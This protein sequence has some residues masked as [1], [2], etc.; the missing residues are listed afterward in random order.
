MTKIAL[1]PGQGSQKVGMGAELFARFPHL[2]EQASNILGYDVRRLCLED[3]E[4]QLNLTQFTQPALFV[5]DTLSYNAYREEHGSVS[6]FAGHSLGEF[7]ALHAAGAFDFATGLRIVQKRGDLMAKASGGGMAAIIGLAPEEIRNVLDDNALTS[8][9]IANFNAPSQT[10]I[11]GPKDDVLA[12]EPAFKAAK[13]R[14]FPLPVSAAFHSR[15]MATAQ[16]A[17]GEFL[18][19]CAIQPLQATVIANCSAKPYTDADL[20]TWLTLQLGNP[21]R[22]VDSMAYLLALSDPEFVEMGPGSVLTGL[23]RQIKGTR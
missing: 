5:V 23:L 7:V 18:A 17:F 3:P 13:G 11:S 6:Y 21:V 2:V 10:V 4:S 19:T 16:Q 20:R 8:I 12:A 1:F 22:W 15:Y 14:F 9:D